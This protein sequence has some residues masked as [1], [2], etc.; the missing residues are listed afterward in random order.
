MKNMGEK[1]IVS[2]KT[3]ESIKTALAMTIAYGIALMMDWDKPMW[4]GFAVAFVSLET[5]G[6][7]FTKAALRMFGTLVAIAVSL[8]IIALFVQD[9]W[10]FMMSLA[11]WVG[12]C[13]YMM[14]GAKHQYLWHVC[15]FV[16]IIICMEVGQSS[17]NFFNV[18]MLCAQ[19]TGLGS[20]FTRPLAVAGRF[21]GTGIRSSFYPP[22]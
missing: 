22:I 16:S 18:A 1:K 14:G 11:A 2:R 9:R 13:T 21:A 7:S 4:A 5:V 15:G 20:R 6:Q 10:L 19:E 3:K 12:Y 8:M 17:A